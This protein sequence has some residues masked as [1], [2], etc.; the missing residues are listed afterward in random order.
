M[1]YKNDDPIDQNDENSFYTLTE[2]IDKIKFINT[3]NEVQLIDVDP[4]LFDNLFKSLNIGYYEKQNINF[5]EIF[6]RLSQIYSEGHTNSFQFAQ[7]YHF[8][9]ICYDIIVK[10][11]DNEFL[12]NLLIC[13]YFGIRSDLNLLEVFS[14]STFCEQLI[15]CMDEKGS[16]IYSIGFNILSNLIK[17]YSHN[18]FD[19]IIYMYNTTPFTSTNDFGVEILNS[20]GLVFSKISNYIDEL[21]YPYMLIMAKSLLLYGAF[22]YSTDILT[23][24]NDRFRS[25]HTNIF[26]SIQLTEDQFSNLS[27]TNQY[28]FL[29][30][31][32]TEEVNISQLEQPIFSYLLS[33]IPQIKSQSDIFHFDFCTTLIKTLSLINKLADHG[34]YYRS[35][36]KPLRSNI[37]VVQYLY[38][39]MNYDEN[40]DIQSQACSLVANIYLTEEYEL[41]MQQ[42]IM[43]TFIR[44]ISNSSMK[45][46]KSC[47]KGII[48]ATSKFTEEQIDDLVK[49]GVLEEMLDFYLGDFYDTQ[50]DIAISFWILFQRSKLARNK[51]LEFYDQFEEIRLETQ[52][53]KLYAR[54]YLILLEL[55]KEKYSWS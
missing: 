12:K 37:Q 31:K 33:S 42:S 3:P 50:A 18:L 1:F 51:G 53:D 43:E 24:L 35:C 29:N 5:I 47:L 4:D 45:V 14:N 22:N 28:Y 6:G 38:E 52:D 13:I 15:Y 30:Y 41:V 44:R 32:S 36:F 46:R 39:L 8:Y 17:G 21:N 40:A 19:K 49:W 2:G 48:N 10:C 9:S 23:N 11:P 27:D 26:L 16:S 20:Y 34:W 55:N 7:K 54:F 25:A